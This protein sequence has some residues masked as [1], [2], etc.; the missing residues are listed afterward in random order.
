MLDFKD[1]TLFNFIDQ[2]FLYPRCAQCKD[3]KAFKYIDSFH[4]F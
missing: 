1:N 4:M 3:E 2:L